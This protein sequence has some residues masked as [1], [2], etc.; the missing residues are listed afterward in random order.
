MK[1]H[2]RNGEGRLKARE[3]VIIKWPLNGLFHDPRDVILMPRMAV[4]GTTDDGP[5][6]YC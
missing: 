5:Y 3:R 1:E 6:H 2:E 4:L